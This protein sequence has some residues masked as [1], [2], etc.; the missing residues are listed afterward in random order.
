MTTT[1]KII[2]ISDIGY[3]EIDAL[4]RSDIAAM[5]RGFNYY[6]HFKGEMTESKAMTLDLPFMRSYWNLMRLKGN[7]R[8]P[9]KA[10]QWLQK[11]ARLGRRITETKPY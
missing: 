3:R 10:S 9:L 2:N 6:K 8:C 4:S 5:R 11:K 1:T 7:I